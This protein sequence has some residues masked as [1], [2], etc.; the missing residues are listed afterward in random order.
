MARIARTRGRI[1]IV[2]IFTEAPKVNLFNVLWRE[3]RLL[4]ARVYEPLDF[5]RAIELAALERLPLDQ[6]S[7]E[8]CPHDLVG[9]ALHRLEAD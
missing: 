9:A 2:A 8:E 3:L 6:L 4:G 5:D 1:V 7:T